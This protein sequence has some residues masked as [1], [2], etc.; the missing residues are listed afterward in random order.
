MEQ[1]AGAFSRATGR[2]LE[3]PT[4]Q[5]RYRRYQFELIAPHCGRAVLEVG[6]GVGEFAAQ[7]LEPDRRGLE[8]LVLTDVDPLA[9]AA[10][11]NR[12]ADDAEVEAWQLDLDELTRTAEAVQRLVDTVVA[13]NVVEHI[14]DD[15]AALRALA[16]LVVPGGSIVLWV[17][18][19]QALYG[20]FDRKVGHFR[21]YTPATLRRAAEDAGLEVTLSQPVNLLG[22]L[23]WW[24]AVRKGGAGSPDPRLVAVYDRFVVPLTRMIERRVRP[25][26]GQSVLCV[27][28][29]RRS[30]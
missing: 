26:F 9:V 1:H 20:D 11:R 30:A 17:P 4:D 14:A 23:A 19:Y 21:R 24:V 7:F 22:G 27:A 16:A 15:V 6:A 18:G 25:P 12:F 10:L 2:D 5:P 28:R 29:T 3:R 13:I 8:R